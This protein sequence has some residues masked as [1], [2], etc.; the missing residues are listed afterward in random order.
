MPA[1]GWCPSRK[2]STNLSEYIQVDMKAVNVIT[3][4]AFGP[5]SGVAVSP[6]ESLSHLKLSV[7]FNQFS[8]LIMITFNS[9]GHIR[10][11]GALKGTLLTLLM[12]QLVSASFLFK[13][14]VVVRGGQKRAVSD[15]P[16]H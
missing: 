10:V 3:K 5:R 16:R 14:F 12:L 8:H 4:I 2:V 13:K 11:I 7:I 9:A 1:G 15:R 6:S